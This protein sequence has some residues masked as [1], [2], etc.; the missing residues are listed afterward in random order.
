M[1]SDDA[2]PEQVAR[3]QALR[4]LKKRRDFRG[5][6]VVYLLVN[7]FLASRNLAGRPVLAAGG[8]FRSAGPGCRPVT[9]KGATA[10]P[11][12]DR[13]RAPLP[14]A[15]GAAMMGAPHPLAARADTRPL[16]G[17]PD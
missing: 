9:V 11:G 17:K 2:T 16:S 6:L 3:E 4:H 14:W 13:E 15:E 8:T 5:H 10:A 7:A 12:G 1:A